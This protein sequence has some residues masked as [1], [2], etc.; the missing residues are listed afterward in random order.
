VLKNQVELANSNEGSDEEVDAERFGIQSLIIESGDWKEPVITYGIVPNSRYIDIDNFGTDDEI[1]IV[2]VSNA[3]AEKFNLGVGDVFTLDEEF[4]NRS[5]EFEVGQVID[6]PGSIAIFME[7]DAFNKVFDLE[8]GSFSG[9]FSNTNLV[10]EG[11]LDESNVATEISRDDYLKISRQLEISIGDLMQLFSLFGIL[12]FMLIVYLLSKIV[13]EKNATSIS[14]IKILGY[15]N[16]EINKI[17]VAA[18][19][20]IVVLSIVITVPLASMLMS[21]LV[22]ALFMSFNGWI[23][24]YAPPLLL[25]EMCGIGIVSYA[26]IAFFMTLRIKKASLSAA[27]KINE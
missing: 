10:D 9:Y 8:E 12:V 6:F 2:S 1:P 26:V 5:Y 18:T 13:I 3:L 21:Y 19:S 22:E 16:G 25:P 7:E 15:R 14:M 27:L 4:E 17:Y 24:Y 20:I 11:I 23:P